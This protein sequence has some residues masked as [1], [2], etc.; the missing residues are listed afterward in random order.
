MQQTHPFDPII[1]EHSSVLF[2]GSFPSLKSFELNFYYAHPR[3]QFWPIME[4]LFDIALPDTPSRRQ[5]ALDRGIALWDVYASLERAAG[6]SS[7][8]NL[9]NLVPNDLPALLKQYPA[10]GHIFCTGKKAYDGL[11]RSFHDLGVGV[12]QLP[13]T[14]PAY[15][16]MRFEEKV[17][18]YAV[19]REYLEND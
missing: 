4:R 5:F 1:D 2:L 13:S 19:I 8:T 16:S 15:A 3:N 9:T 17:K 12:T 7:D 11:M 18:A 6:N 14:S 10:V